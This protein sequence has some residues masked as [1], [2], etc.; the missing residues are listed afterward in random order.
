[1]MS[2][3]IYVHEDLMKAEEFCMRSL[4]IR[5]NLLGENH[6]EV[7]ETFNNLGNLYRHM[8]N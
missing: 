7:A 8:V 5:Q 3:L 1:M 6:F 2:V 4:K